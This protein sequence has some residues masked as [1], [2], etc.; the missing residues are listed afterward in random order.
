MVIFPDQFI[1]SSRQP[2]I[3]FKKTVFIE[4]R[5][6]IIF[7]SKVRII[8]AVHVLSVFEYESSNIIADFL[9]PGFSSKKQVDWVVSSSGVYPFCNCP[10][11]SKTVFYW[12]QER[13][14]GFRKG[15]TRFLI[16]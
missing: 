11:T 3:F 8:E 5:A 15:G 16:G 4:V 1:Q 14:G 7:F 12:G 9:I 2:I 10:K 13:E 6:T